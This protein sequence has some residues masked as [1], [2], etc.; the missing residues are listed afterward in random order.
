MLT[1]YMRIILNKSFFKLKIIHILKKMSHLSI[2]PSTDPLQPTT[3][4]VSTPRLDNNESY[5]ISSNIIQQ[6]VTFVTAYI[7][8]LEDRST[9]KSP[10]VRFD[11][12]RRLAQSGIAI[13]LFVSSTYI[14][15][16][17][18]ICKIYP[19]IYLMPTIELTD[20]WTYQTTILSNVALPD[21]RNHNKDTH[22]FMV[23]MNAKPEFIYKTIKVNPFKS[24]HF[25]WIDF[26]IGHVISS[27]DTFTQLFDIGRS[28]QFNHENVSIRQGQLQEKM[29][30]IPGCW[31]KDLSHDRMGDV[32]NAVNWRFCGGF[33]LGDKKSLIEFYDYYQH[34]YTHFLVQT[35]K[36]SWEVN[37]WAWLED[38]TDWSPEF[39]PAD[40]NDTILKIP[41]Q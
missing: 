8:L 3:T 9:E 29:L 40:H 36:L 12:F 4:N 34:H 41:S 26:S 31:S 27:D 38:T 22:N 28:P 37:F 16:V 2:H 5:D 17:K 13:C 6:K 15:E 35:G 7:D 39:Y 33:F 19:N 14:E 1:R 20:T 21:Q 10:Q 25:A 18:E 23:L 30:V 32:G 24:T 11:Q